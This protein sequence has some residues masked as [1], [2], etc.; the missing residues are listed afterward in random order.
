MMNNYYYARQLRKHII[1]FMAAFAGLQ[2]IVGKRDDTEPRL[3][4]VPVHYGAKDR[5][6]AAILAENTQNEPLRLPL[7]SC[8]VNRLDVA[9]ELQVGLSTT[10]RETFL[11]PGGMLPDDIQTIKQ[12]KPVAY[13]VGMELNIYASNTD[14]HF[15]ILEQIMLLFYPGLQIQTSD[16][17][18]D[19]TKITMIELENI[20]LDQNYPS[21]T[22]KRII[23]SQ[24][25]FSFPMYLSAPAD[26]KNNYVRD[27]YARIGQLSNRAPSNPSSF[28]IIEDFDLQDLEYE[29]VVSGNELKVG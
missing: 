6:V 20:A 9:P 13:R 5:I 17:P 15:Q 11:P 22:D 28:D 12:L 8:Y 21:G 27:V 1:Q 23:Q 19:W 26:L 25:T 3:I 24:C 2:V 18:F 16:A 7:M 14:Q 10:R 4:N 29:L